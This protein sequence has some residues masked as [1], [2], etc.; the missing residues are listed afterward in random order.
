[1]PLAPADICVPLAFER[2][3][4]P[5]AVRTNVYEVLR[6][7]GLPTLDV[8]EDLFRLAASVYCADT[9]V[10]RSVAYADWTRAITVHVPVRQ[11]DLWRSVGPTLTDMLA[12][13]TGDHW[14]VRFREACRLETAQAPVQ[15]LPS[16]PAAVSLFSGGL[17]SFI[18]AVDRLE[19]G[20]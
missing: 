10:P 14:E 7:Q 13:L 2:P 15:I 17:D 18:G 5:H 11:A 4:D 20:E 3:G 19:A 12:F 6:E 9:R 16:P 8:G 1:P